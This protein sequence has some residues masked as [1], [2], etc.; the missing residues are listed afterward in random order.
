MTAERHRRNARAG[1]TARWRPP[2]L[3]L[4]AAVAVLTTVGAPAAV[5]V[6]LLF[7]LDQYWGG[8]RHVLADAAIL[9]LLLLPAVWFLGSSEPLF[10]PAPRIEDN[11]AA[12]QIGGAVVWLLALAVMTDHLRREERVSS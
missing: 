6:T 8:H 10:P 4:L 5:A 2:V 3:T 12:H 1:R 11:A 7:L 9:G